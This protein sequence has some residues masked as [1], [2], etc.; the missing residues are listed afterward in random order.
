MAISVAR[1]L[2]EEL[3]GIFPSSALNGAFKRASD[4]SKGS[5][6]ANPVFTAN[7]NDASDPLG[8][9]GT[10]ITVRDPQ[11][12]YPGAV[13][14]PLCHYIDCLC[15]GPP[16][17]EPKDQLEPL[18]NFDALQ[19][20]DPAFDLPTLSPKERV[21]ML[22]ER[23][24]YDIAVQYLYHVFLEADDAG[25]LAL[26]GL[27][28]ATMDTLAHENAADFHL[29]NAL[30]VL[31]GLQ[32]VSSSAEYSAPASAAAPAAGGGGPAP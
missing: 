5:E 21:D 19:M 15:V 23:G 10:L 11:N 13:E 26:T 14:C 28:E 32:P 3:E 4:F 16:E 8:P 24:D 25:K 9:H 17:P 6:W 1:H 20:A 7:E 31:V 27:I 22:L 18:E 12:F 30:R 2:D 29:V